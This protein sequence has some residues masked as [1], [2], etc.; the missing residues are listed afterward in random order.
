MSARPLVWTNG[1]SSRSLVT[2]SASPSLNVRL[3]AGDPNSTPIYLSVGVRDQYG[4]SFEFDMPPVRITPETTNIAM[5]INA[6]QST[7]SHSDATNQLSS[8]EIVQI[9]TNG[10]G[11]A[12]NQALVSLSQPLNAMSI[13]ALR[14]ALM[15]MPTVHSNDEDVLFLLLQRTSLP[16]TCVCHCWIDH[17]HW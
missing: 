13:D 9:L 6:L 3:P 5:L 2:F 17:G 7:S 10:N 8:N 1:R 15:G 14:I 16:L 4:C 12:V 11:N